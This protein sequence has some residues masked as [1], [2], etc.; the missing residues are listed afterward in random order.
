MS[1]TFVFIGWISVVVAGSI[2][3]GLQLGRYE[4]R[5]QVATECE[6]LG[7]FYVGQKT[8]ECKVK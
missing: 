1:D 2:F 5:H 8:F 3:V 6:R 7:A 4:A